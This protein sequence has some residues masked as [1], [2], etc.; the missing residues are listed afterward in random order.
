[1]GS[2]L[3]QRQSALARLP[4]AFLG[5]AEDDPGFRAYEKLLVRQEKATDT[6]LTIAKSHEWTLGFRAG[7]LAAVE[8]AH[9]KIGDL[10]KNDSTGH[11]KALRKIGFA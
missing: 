8:A 9:K 2:P 10:L 1:M 11:A 7:V 4:Q 6:W 5:G 3:F